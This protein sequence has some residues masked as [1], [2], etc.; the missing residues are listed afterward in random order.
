MTDTSTTP[1]TTGRPRRAARSRLIAAVA[2]LGVAA[3]L[4]GTGVHFARTYWREPPTV[5][6][7]SAVAEKKVFTTTP[8]DGT[9][10]APVDRPLRAELVPEGVTLDP[11]TVGPGTVTLFRVSDRSAVPARVTV[12][13]GGRALALTPDEPLQPRTNYAWT[14]GEGVRDTAGQPVAPLQ[15]AFCTAPAGPLQLPAF[16]QVPLPVT[17]GLGVTCVTIGPDGRL[18]G[19]VDDG[20]ILRFDIDANGT[21]S[22]KQEYQSLVDANGGQPRLI[23]GIAF[24]PASTAERPVL[25]VTHTSFGFINMGDWQGAVARMSGPNL[26]KV[27]PVVVNLPRSARDHILH[28]PNFGPDGCL[29]FQSGSM[30][31]YG[32]PDGYWGW[33]REHPLSAAVIRIDPKKLPAKLPLDVKTLDDGG[34]YDWRSPDAPVTVFAGGMRV[35]YDVCW[36]SSGRLFAAVNGS[37]Q[38][39]NAPAGPNAPLLWAIPN[40]EHDWLFRV[41]PGGYYGHPN[42]SQGKYVLNGGNPTTGPD[43]AEQPAYPV[44]TRPEKNW[45]PAVF[46][47]GTHVSPNGMTEYR[48]DGPLDRAL[49]VCRYN[50]GNDL[51]AI[52]IDEKGNVAGVI[53][54]VPGWG[55]L[56]NPLDVCQD[57]VRGNLYVSEYGKHA[58]TLLR[59]K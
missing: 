36:H 59:R 14:I 12:E 8:T 15:M 28:Q 4:A 44:G 57:P 5:C 6:E 49:I 13:S 37:S 10:D 25:W 17:E 2:V 52:K 46:D 54:N 1:S 38:G 53:A 23:G 50:V 29:Y 21:L 41:E 33:R 3:V 30:N 26:E 51:L 43:F 55:N 22:N 34:R 56:Q 20:R 16:E 19:A 58:I 42:P 31:S 47:F 39:G 18:W 48:G 32:E 9:A 11:A 35:A 7:E 27:E 24:D 40:S 45:Q